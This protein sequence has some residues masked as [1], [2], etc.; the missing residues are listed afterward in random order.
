[1]WPLPKAKKDAFAQFAAG[2]TFAFEV[3]EPGFDS[4][5]HGGPHP[6]FYQHIPVSPGS[7]RYKSET[8]DLACFKTQLGL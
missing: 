5:E 2:L 6:Y 3:D 7:S 1:M 8:C 4:G